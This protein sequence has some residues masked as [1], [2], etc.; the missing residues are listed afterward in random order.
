MKPLKGSFTLEAVVVMSSIIMIL[1][2][3]LYAFMIMYQ[4]VIVTYAASYAAQQGAIT[5]VNSGLNI[6]DGTGNY[7]SEIYY[8]IAEVVGDGKVSEKKTKIENCVRE[9][10][11]AGILSSDDS[12]VNV[13]L[14][15]YIFQRQIHVEVKQNIPIPFSGIVKFFND[16]QGFVIS[17]KSIAVVPEPT[18]YIRNCDYAI[19]TATVLIDYLNEKLHISDGFEKIKSAIGALN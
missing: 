5:W 13:E 15:N 19:E 11:K 12:T 8:R 2:A 18:E 3:I 17:T 7:N 10:L 14:K 1:F 9:K 6:D 4:N 16:G